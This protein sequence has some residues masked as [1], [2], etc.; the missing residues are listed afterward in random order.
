MLMVDKIFKNFRINLE[1]LKNNLNY[2][3]YRKV[4]TKKNLNKKVMKNKTNS[5][6][7]PSILNNNM[8]M[9][10]NI[11]LLIKQKLYQT[12]KKIVINKLKILTYQNI[13]FGNEL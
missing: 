13:N 1:Y 9:I 3:L 12:M 7:F 4:I 10:N 6:T 8:S 11:R 5:K 2:K